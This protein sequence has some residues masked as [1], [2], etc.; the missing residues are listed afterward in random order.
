[1]KTDWEPLS[2]PPEALLQLTSRKNTQNSVPEHFAEASRAAVEAYG[3]RH[4]TGTGKPVRSRKMAEK[5]KENAQVMTRRSALRNRHLQHVVDRR[6]RSQALPVPG[7]F[8]SVYCTRRKQAAAQP[9][10]SSVRSAGRRKEPP[11]GLPG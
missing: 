2:T 1:M 7:Q 3:N 10:Q 4:C 5:L 11:A 8:V 9:H 6:R